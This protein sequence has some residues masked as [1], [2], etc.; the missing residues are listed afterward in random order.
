[1]YT[2]FI[3]IRLVAL[4]CI[5]KDRR[6]RFTIPEIISLLPMISRLRERLPNIS[7]FEKPES[8][9]SLGSISCHD[10]LF[11]KSLFSIFF[12][13]KMSRCCF[14]N[15]LKLVSR[16]LRRIA[17]A[18]RVYYYLDVKSI[19]YGLA[20]ALE[21]I[22][23]KYAQ[24]KNQGRRT[25]KITFQN[26]GQEDQDLQFLPQTLLFLCPWRFRCEKDHFQIP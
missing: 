11:S 3:E 6:M 14:W 1:M 9:F 4:S 19:R 13:L 26:A 21:P 7:C 23:R 15:A 24:K 2:F 16:R 25:E 22:N 12:V 5:W 10:S 18:N 20:A 8:R 17:Q